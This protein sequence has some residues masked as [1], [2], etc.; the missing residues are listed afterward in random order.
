MLEI[1]VASNNSGK[2]REVREI[3]K[4]YKIIS[5][6]DLGIN[7]EVEE[8]GETFEENA[9]KKA[10]E[11]SKKLGG[12]LCLA[13]DSGIEIE[14]LQGFP[15]VQTKRWYKGT[16][17]ERNAEILKKLENVPKEQR[18]VKFVAAVS[19][20]DGEKTICKKASIDGY[21]AKSP[22][23]ENGFGFDEIFELANGRTLAE[24]SFEEKNQISSRK[25]AIEKISNDVK[26]FTKQE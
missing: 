18:K 5:L 11:I 4:E 10:E 24:L 13:D 6:S 14:Y 17:K 16:E 23:G 21:I 7:I 15:G 3:L 1:V 8:N 2:I 25:K 12:K 26:N 9:T 19:L 20:S 22:R